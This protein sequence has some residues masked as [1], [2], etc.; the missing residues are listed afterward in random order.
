MIDPEQRMITVRRH[1]SPMIIIMLTALLVIAGCG[2]PGNGAGGGRGNAPSSSIGAGKITGRITVLAAASLTEAFTT[3]GKNFRTAHP[4]TSVTFSFGSSSTL[5]TQVN[6]GAPGDVFA[7]A[8]ERT[9]RLVTGAGNAGDPRI[10]ATNTLEIAV[11]PGN[12]GKITG[13]ADFA[14]GSKKTALCAEE[15]PCGAAARRV[16]AKAGITPE[17]A[18]YETDVKAALRKVEQDEVDA[19]LVYRTDV[20]AAG[21]KVDG[22]SFPEAASVINKYPIVVLNG[23]AN[24]ATAAAFADYVTGPGERILGRAGFGAT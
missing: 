1:R 22:I 9:M 14:D 8:D 5:A 19:A 16:F 23:S 20:A 15:V 3:I 13:L 4:G 6:Q 10:F 11:P 2:G 18:S 12:P 21:D 7:S 24:S 17:P